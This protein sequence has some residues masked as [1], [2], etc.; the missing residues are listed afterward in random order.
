MSASYGVGSSFVSFVLFH[1]FDPAAGASKHIGHSCGRNVFNIRALS[2]CDDVFMLYGYY[3]GHRLRATSSCL[4]IEALE[5]VWLV[6]YCM[7]EPQAGPQQSS[8]IAGKLPPLASC[9][10]LKASLR[11]LQSSRVQVRVR[12]GSLL[13]LQHPENIGSASCCSS[14]LWGQAQRQDLGWNQ[15][16]L[17]QRDFFG[18][19]GD[20]PVVGTA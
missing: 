9:V 13:L 18:D 14:S 7:F 20:Y 2:G 12:P 11:A 17:C 4:P 10:P 5:I 3:F 19:Y 15:G 1:C 6:W 8:L 16:P